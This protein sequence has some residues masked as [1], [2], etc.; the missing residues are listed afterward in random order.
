MQSFHWHV[1][2][3]GFPSWGLS[4]DGFG[5]PHALVVVRQLLQDREHSVYFG[6]VGMNYCEWSSLQKGGSCVRCGYVLRR[7]YDRKP[8]R[9]CDRQDDPPRKGLGDYVADGLAIVGITKPVVTTVIGA[10]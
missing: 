3:R 4:G 2:H 6:F 10:P 8:G 9:M 5:L 7:D 1:R